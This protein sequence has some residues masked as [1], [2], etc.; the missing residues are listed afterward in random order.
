MNVTPSSSLS[1][2]G[3]LRARLEKL[4]SPAPGVQGG[5]DK[6]DIKEEGVKSF[7]EPFVSEIRGSKGASFVK[8]TSFATNIGGED[9]SMDNEQSDVK[10]E[11]ENDS[12]MRGNDESEVLKSVSVQDTR[13]EEK[14]MEDR[15][16][17]HRKAKKYSVSVLPEDPKDFLNVCKHT[18]GKSGG[19]CLKSM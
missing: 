19:F 2:L 1:G 8:T 7:R 18:I 16:P 4:T 9:L 17:R 13:S 11:E 5:D 10:M 12:E 14:S 15:L 3:P 6:K